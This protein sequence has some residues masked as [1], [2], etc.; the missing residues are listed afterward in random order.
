VGFEVKS[1]AKGDSAGN[2]TG[3]E[4]AATQV[5]RGM[6][7][8]I[9]FYLRDVGLLAEVGLV[10]LVPVIFTTAR[11]WISEA[12]LQATDIQ[13][14]ELSGEQGNL[15]STD[16]IWYQYHVSPGIK[17]ERE[18]PRISLE[19]GEALDREFVRSVAIVTPAGIRQFLKWAAS[20]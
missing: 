2:K 16:W 7:G 1:Q 11:L 3:I 18:N 15:E 10:R 19:L 9:E 17:H 12:N 5:C 6:N 4:D 20:L 14:G 8:L 13:T